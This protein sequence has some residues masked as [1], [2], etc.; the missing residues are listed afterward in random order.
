M[1]RMFNFIFLAILCIILLHSPPCHSAI[2]QADNLEYEVK[3]ACIFNFLKFIQFPPDRNEQIITVCIVGKEPTGA[4]ISKVLSDKQIGG[5]RIEIKIFPDIAQLLAE[6]KKYHTVFL[7]SPVEGDI[8]AHVAS[9]RNAAILTI[10][11]TPDFCQKGG[12]INFRFDNGKL[13][14]DINLQAAKKSNLKISSHLLKL[15][16]ITGQVSGSLNNNVQK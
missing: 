4:I 7:A 12:I 2:G 1:V 11:E 6:G 14:F 8:G 10:G 13:R 9:L 15:A 3:S 5:K 16:N